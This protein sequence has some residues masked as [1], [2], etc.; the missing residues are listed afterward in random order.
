MEQPFQAPQTEMERR[1]ST[2]YKDVLRID[3]VGID[4]NFFDLGGNSLSLVEVHSRLQDLVGRQFSVAELFAYTTV[5]KLA[6][7]FSH[8]GSGNKATAELLSRAQ[9]QRQAIGAGRNRRRQ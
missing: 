2:I 9:R 7:R 4:D 6:A 8:N 1:I 5:R 3:K